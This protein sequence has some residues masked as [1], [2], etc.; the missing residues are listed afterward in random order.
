MKLAC[1]TVY[2]VIAHCRL[3]DRHQVEVAHGARRALPGPRAGVAV[4]AGRAHGAHLRACAHDRHHSRYRHHDR[5]A[6]LGRRLSFGA[7]APVDL[8]LPGRLRRGGRK[9]AVPPERARVVAGR[10]RDPLRSR[11]PAGDRRDP[12]PGLRARAAAGGT[13]RLRRALLH[14]GREQQRSIRRWSPS[15]RRTASRSRWIAAE[16]RAERHRP[17]N[18][19]VGHGLNASYSRDG[20]STLPR[21]TPNASA[22]S[23]TSSTAGS[24]HRPTRTSSS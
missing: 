14:H 12:G 13:D 9:R 1:P 3:P 5:L 18:R 17:R 11:L 4:H 21:P 2:T 23:A 8:L 15:S 22:T 24:W 20:G 19:R 10:A 7:D 16:S 6:R